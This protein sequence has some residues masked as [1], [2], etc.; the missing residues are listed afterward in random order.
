M[1]NK[2]AWFGL[3]GRRWRAAAM[4]KSAVWLFSGN[5]ID[6]D[7]Q[8]APQFRFLVIN[9]RWHPGWAANAGGQR[10]PVYE[11]NGFMMGVSIPVQADHI[12]LVFSP[13][14]WAFG[15]A[16]HEVP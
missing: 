1:W 5:R 10:L 2:P 14:A 8:P 6:I 3:G 13:F 9:S 7:L 16:A 12:Q 11:A 15:R 4:P